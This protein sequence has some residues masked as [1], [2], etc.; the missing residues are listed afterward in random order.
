MLE[1]PA[2]TPNP[3]VS[4]HRD[5]LLGYHHC[6][7]AWEPETRMTRGLAHEEALLNFPE[8][9]LSGWAVPLLGR[10]WSTRQGLQEQRFEAHPLP[11]P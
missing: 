10:R 4:P 5:P 6:R 11:G 9:V 1:R 2:G 7:R 3:S 8:W